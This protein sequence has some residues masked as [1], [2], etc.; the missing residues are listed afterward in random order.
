MEGNSLM[1]NML[2]RKKAL[3]MVMAVPFFV[4]YLLGVNVSS[5]FTKGDERK[6]E[7]PKA[8]ATQYKPVKLLNNS[9][10]GQK[11]ENNTRLSI[12]DFQRRLRGNIKMEDLK[13]LFDQAFDAQNYEEYLS[14]KKRAMVMQKWGEMAPMQGLE[15]LKDI[16]DGADFLSSLFSGWASKD[17]LAALACYEENYTG[18]VV[19][20]ATILSSIIGEYA[21]QFP[22]DA[23]NSLT[24]HQEGIPPHLFDKVKYRFL[25]A[26]AQSNP[27]LIPEMVEKVGISTEPT[28]Q[29]F[30]KSILYNVGVNWG[31]HNVESREWL[32]KLPSELK[33]HAEAGRIMGITKGDLEKIDEY[34]YQLP[35]EDRSDTLYELVG[36]LLNGGLDRAERVNWI[37]NSQISEDGLMQIR[38]NMERWFRWDS[39]N[40]VPWIESLPPGERKELLQKWQKNADDYHIRFNR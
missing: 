31:K 13:E 11:K 18:D 40:S 15:K 29:H 4:A 39:K 35:L 33:G 17:P 24:S 30:M 21:L 12:A 22:E 16:P 26:T 3:I 28:N 37:I 25:K 14:D 20:S 8:D 10:E 23:W 38:G 5:S 2:T 27:E 32:E 34:F 36:P 9:I 1:I 6:K 19:Y 7:T